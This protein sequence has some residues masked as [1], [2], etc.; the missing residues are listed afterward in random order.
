LSPPFLRPDYFNCLAD[1][2]LTHVE[3]GT[4]SLSDPVLQNLHKPF[5]SENVFKAQQGA[6]EAGLHIAHYF[7]LG[8]PGENRETLQTTLTGIDKLEKRFSF[9]L[10]HSHLSAHGAV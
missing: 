6:L 8:G 10:R 7:L 1:A 2:G 5:K 9:F 3:F 4:E